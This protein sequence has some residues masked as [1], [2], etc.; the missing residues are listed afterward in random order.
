MVTL[1]AP[2]ETDQFQG[3][4]T[5]VHQP[6]VSALPQPLV[7]VRWK[8]SAAAVPVVGVLVGIGVVVVAF[9]E[10]FTACAD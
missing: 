5:T 7:T 6:P 1:P 2:G 4:P 3:E 8:L 10:N 9:P